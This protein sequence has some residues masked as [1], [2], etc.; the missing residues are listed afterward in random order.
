MIFH[1]R[2][3]VLQFVAGEDADDRCIRGDDAF[4]QQLQQARVTAVINDVKLLPSQAAPRPAS[5]RGSACAG[6]SRSNWVPRSLTRAAAAWLGCVGLCWLAARPAGI[7]RDIRVLAGLGVVLANW[8]SL[9]ALVRRRL[10]RPNRAQFPGD[11]GFRFRFLGFFFLAGGFLRIAPRET[12][13]HYE[14]ELLQS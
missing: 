13:L 8:A 5:V 1:R 11:D 2:V 7:W 6:R 10:I 9:A 12:R 3:R 4:G 14:V